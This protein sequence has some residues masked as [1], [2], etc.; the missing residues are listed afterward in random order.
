MGKS[1]TVDQ[2]S[3]F[4]FVIPV[5]LR[6]RNSTGYPPADGPA[7]DYLS[8]SRTQQDALLRSCSFLHG[9]FVQ[10]V[11]VLKEDI[12]GFTA[13]R[14]R[15]YMRKGMGFRGHGPNRKAFYEAVT[16]LAEGFYTSTYSMF[17]LS[18]RRPSDN[19]M[20]KLLLSTPFPLR[21]AFQDL[22]KVLGDELLPELP[23]DRPPKK[24]KKSNANFQRS[25]HPLVVIAFDE[26]H[27]LAKPRGQDPWSPFHEMRRALRGLRTLSLFTLFLST[28]ATL[29]WIP[30][31]PGH[32]SS[33]R[34]LLEG[35]AV[36]PF[37][38]LGFD[39]FALPLDFSKT[40]KLSQVTSEEH[41]ISY[42]RPLYVLNA[43]STQEDIIFRFAA[44]K[45]LGGTAYEGQ[46]L[47][48]PQKLGCLAQRIPIEFLSAVY[49]SQVSD[50]EKE[51]VHS[52]MR[53]VL[54]VGKNL[55]TMVTTSPSEPVLSEAAYFVMTTQTQFSPPQA[56][57][58]ILNEFAVNKGELGELMVTLL[59]TMARD[60]AVGRA[61]PYGRPPNNRRWCSLTGLLTSLFHT[62][63]PPS[64]NH[65]NVITSCGWHFAAGSPKRIKSSLADTFDDSKVYFTHFIKV[66]QHALV[67]VEYLMRLM[68]R[69]AAV[70]CAN[71]QPGIDGIIP[72]LL[73]GDE[74]RAD[75]IGVI[76]FQVK[77]D[78]S[79][80][81]SPQQN[82]FHAMDPCS[83]GVS[84]SVPVIR[85]VFALAAN[86]PG[87][88]LAQHSSPDTVNPHRGHKSTGTTKGSYTT[89]DIWVAGLSSELLVPV[90]NEQST[91]DSILQASHSWEG[92]YSDHSSRRATLR[93]SM[94]PEAATDNGFWQSW[95]NPAPR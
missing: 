69:G 72:F 11:A 12:K 57:Q 10:I 7:R 50:Q 58:E 27:T 31:T 88:V 73:K 24:R 2:M 90:G 38:E 87:L 78:R 13:E 17:L 16:T 34:I 25:E 65:V 28:S 49:A 15:D 9:L 81:N 6:E 4:R 32:D 80:S 36:L 5:N 93:R 8:G 71:G 77:N 92:I 62:A 22:C 44:A 35:E 64:D 23:T 74:I 82:L 79:Y 18:A 95:C 59:F 60:K 53:V 85:I 3:R 19:D 30:P 67:H 55:E 20:D 42:G 56:L 52:H 63:S 51:Q 48:V 84:N 47:N 43:L 29:C 14:F 91:W 75:N 41:L 26:I 89:Y 37:C 40:V 83:L 39:E 66:H 1:R 94:N 76:L 61:D 21:K 70:L 33:A 86:T 68:A 46:I 45:L 54:K